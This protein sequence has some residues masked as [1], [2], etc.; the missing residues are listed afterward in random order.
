MKVLS[1]FASEVTASSFFTFLWVPVKRRLVF[2]SFEAGEAAVLRQV[3]MT[4]HML[5]QVSLAG[6]GFSTIRALEWWWFLDT[7]DFHVSFQAHHVLECF[8]TCWCW[9]CMGCNFLVP[10]GVRLEVH[11]FHVAFSTL[12]TFKRWPIPR[13]MCHL[14]VLVEVAG[15]FVLTP[16]APTQMRLVWGGCMFRFSRLLVS[17]VSLRRHTDSFL[18]R[19]WHNFLGTVEEAV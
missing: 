4:V 9:A 1:T 5:C 3:I 15:S 13:P 6:E 7:T 19:S 2:K 11:T 17:L 16:T 10:V 12:F 18:D 14:G 8:A